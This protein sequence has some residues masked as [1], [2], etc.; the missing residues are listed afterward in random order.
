MNPCCC[1]TMIDTF[2]IYHTTITRMGT[3]IDRKF[4]FIKN[5]TLCGHIIQC[6]LAVG[7]IM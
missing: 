6:N 3:A 5:T 1:S 4:F 2:C 7:S